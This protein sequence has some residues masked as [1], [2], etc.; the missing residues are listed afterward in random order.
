MWLP[1]NTRSRA[2]ENRDELN[3]ASTPRFQLPSLAL[4]WLLHHTAADGV[5][6]GAP[7]KEQFDHNLAAAAD[8]PLS[9]DVVAVCDRVWGSLCGVAPQYH[10]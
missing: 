9:P 3:Q 6:L 8:G 1:K 4:G 10:R 7:R 2:K 5:I